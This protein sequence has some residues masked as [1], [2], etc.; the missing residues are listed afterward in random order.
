MQRFRLVLFA[1]VLMFSVTVCG[2]GGPASA[3]EG[4][5]LIVQGKWNW[6]LSNNVGSTTG[7]VDFTQSSNVLTGVLT[8]NSG[9]YPLNGTLDGGDVKFIVSIGG[10]TLTFTGAVNKEGTT[11]T[12][13]VESSSGQMGVW[14]AARP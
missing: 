14:K 4:T 9:A 2:G 3:D 8:D 1:V 5:Q 11:I 13:T 7:T 10:G 6:V 12:T